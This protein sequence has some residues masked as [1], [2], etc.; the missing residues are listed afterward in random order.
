MLSIIFILQM[1]RYTNSL[2]EVMPCANSDA[3]MNVGA[4]NANAPVVNATQVKPIV[5]QTYVL[6]LDNHGMHII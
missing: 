6:L 4:Q 3:L 5:D 2:V 1:I